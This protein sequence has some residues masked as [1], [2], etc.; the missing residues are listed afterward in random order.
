[1]AKQL[2]IE[3]DDNEIRV[4]A[5]R[6]RG[7]RFVV[8]DVFTVDI[9]G[10]KSDAIGKQLADALAERGLQKLPTLVAIGRGRAELRQLSLP[11]I[12]DEELPDV[13][14]F[15][16]VRQ[17]AAA[18]ERAAIDYLPIARS[19]TAVE[20]AAAALAP[21]H[22]DEIRR[23]C[24]P[25]ELQLQRIVLR[26][27]AAA[28]LFQLL[29]QP[30]SGETILIDTLADEVDLI[31]MRGK[32]PAFLRSVRV[33]TDEQA[34][35]RTIVNETRRSLMAVR[36]D[37]SNSSQRQII[38]W[39]NPAFHTELRQQLTEQLGIEAKSVDP[40]S[41]VETPAELPNGMP[42][43]VG[44]FA[45]LLGLLEGDVLKGQGLID[46]LNPRRPPE[47]KS[48]R[49]RYAL[50]GGLAAALVL[51]IGWLAWSQLSRLDAKYQQTLVASNDLNDAVAAAQISK[52]NLARIDQFL[53]GDVFMLGELAYLS[54]NLGPAE[55]M[56]IE[57]LTVAADPRGG[58][59]M[60]IKGV[61]REPAAVIAMESQL[62]DA[63]HAVTGDGVKSDPRNE[64]FK[65]QFNDTIRI[66]AAS[67]RE[68]RL[69]APVATDTAELKAAPTDVKEP[70]AKTEEPAAAEADT[71]PEGSGEE[72][73]TTAEAATPA[74]DSEQ[75]DPAAGE[76]NADESE[77]EET[78]ADASDSDASESDG[79]K[80]DEVSA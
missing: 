75:A 80:S 40:F 5:A 37:G 7:N 9:S 50:Y 79:S 66:P 56:R 43:H 48:N 14:R 26:P 46:F 47:P 1:M 20:V 65:F 60:A 73:S 77:T 51:L 69:A 4:V 53:D 18:G 72:E 8:T 33:P 49:D 62:R 31:V 21:E 71:T 3:W 74:N 76:P 63:D 78:K 11:A 52:A 32:T 67:V 15:Q 23:V 28:A 45:P 57:Q 2:A 38:V 12:P 41:L 61:A 64:T 54:E 36:R 25:S 30:D 34:R 59:T 39:G 58:A 13:V 16:A 27:T 29:K 17:F 42:Q 70:P 44:R 19:E 22:I 6:P 24:A 10:A 68:Q 35:L 55:Q